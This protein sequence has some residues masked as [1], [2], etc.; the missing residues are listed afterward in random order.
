M[1]INT[2]VQPIHTVSVQTAQ[3]TIHTVSVQTAQ[4]TFF[5]RLFDGSYETLDSVLYRWR[6][7][8]ASFVEHQRFIAH[9]ARQFKFLGCGGEEK[10][11]AQR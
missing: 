4:K 3:K 5:S 9:G 2:K 6:P 7:A 8:A 11:L 10:K 1:S